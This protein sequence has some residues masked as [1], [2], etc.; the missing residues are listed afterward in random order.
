MIPAR[1]LLGAFI[2]FIA[3]AP[4]ILS[5]FHVALLNY[6][7][8]ATMVSLGLVLLTGVAGVMSF[9]QQVFA[10]IAAYTTALI[11][12]AY[13]GS[14]WLALVIGLALV[15]VVA[16]FL[17]AITLRLSG[18]TCRSRP[19]PGASRSTSCSATSRSSASTPAY[20]MFR[21]WRARRS[22]TT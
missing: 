7:A 10:G 4:F 12:T 13:G 20:P 8:L 22:C 21:A 14:P 16:L 9:G 3:A 15:A 5:E 19:S 2:G 11:T 1:A 6:I 17:G 18:T